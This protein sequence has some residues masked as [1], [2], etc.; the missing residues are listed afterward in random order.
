[1][2]GHVAEELFIGEKFITTGVGG[3]LASATELAY[4][5]VRNY[6]MY[7]DTTGYISA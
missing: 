2:G 6:G 4:T 7:G 5:A 1:M 3:D